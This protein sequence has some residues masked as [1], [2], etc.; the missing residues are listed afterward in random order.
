MALGSGLSGGELALLPVILQ[1]FDPGGKF[2]RR[3]GH[4]NLE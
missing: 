1:P 2:F 3:N 4:S